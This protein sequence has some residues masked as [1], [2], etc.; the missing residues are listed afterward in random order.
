[1]KIKEKDMSA[2]IE[3]RNTKEKEDIQK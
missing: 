1:M 2:T 3:R